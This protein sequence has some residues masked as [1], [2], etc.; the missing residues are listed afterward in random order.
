MAFFQ[1]MYKY[2]SSLDINTN[3][4]SQLADIDETQERW[5]W[6][7]FLQVLS[8]EDQLQDDNPNQESMGSKDSVRFFVPLF[9]PCNSI[10]PHANVTPNVG[11]GRA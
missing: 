1:A 5:I 7:K 2:D 8:T 9:H 10:L 6:N 11:S 3:R 4:Y